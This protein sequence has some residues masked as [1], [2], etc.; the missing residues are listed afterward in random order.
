MSQQPTPKQF[1]LKVINYR[2]KLIKKGFGHIDPE[3]KQEMRNIAYNVSN[4]K[5]AAS[6]LAYLRRKKEIF[7]YIIPANKKSWRQTFQHLI[8]I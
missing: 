4:S 5:T 3:L 8:E 1:V 6:L 7:Q 2:Q